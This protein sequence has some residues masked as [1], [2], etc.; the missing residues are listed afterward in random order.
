[1]ISSREDWS[2]GKPDAVRVA[3]PSGSHRAQKLLNPSSPAI[4]KEPTRKYKIPNPGLG[5][6]D[7]AWSYTFK[8]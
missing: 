2:T 7:T 5:P 4:R 8:S 3:I 1:M 6:E